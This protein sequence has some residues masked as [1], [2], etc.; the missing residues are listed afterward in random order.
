M[1][2]LIRLS[3]FEGIMTLSWMLNFTAIAFWGISL[4]GWSVAGEKVCRN[5]IRYEI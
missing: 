4:T 1:I 5:F 2:S 3:V